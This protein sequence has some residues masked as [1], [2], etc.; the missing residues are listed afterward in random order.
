MSRARFR[1]W[2]T[3]NRPIF[4]VESRRRSC[5]EA[6]RTRRLTVVRGTFRDLRLWARRRRFSAGRA[7]AIT[8]LFSAWFLCL[9]KDR[10]SPN[11]R[12]NGN[13][14]K[15][16]ARRCR[17]ATSLPKLV[18]SS[19]WRVRLYPLL[20]DSWKLETAGLRRVR[21]LSAFDWVWFDL[22]LLRGEVFGVVAIFSGHTFVFCTLTFCCFFF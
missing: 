19:G 13:V 1:F 5:F 11:C 15:Y 12:F 21:A 2:V 16:A 17:N 3:T 7:L 20:K 9:A 6:R 22:G 10:S 8:F 14:R 4:R 18:G